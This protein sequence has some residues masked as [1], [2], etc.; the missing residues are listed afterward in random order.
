MIAAYT[1]VSLILLGRGVFCGWLC[2]FG[3]LQELLGQIGRALRLPQWSPTATT[4]RWLLS[5]KYVLA[6]GL[7]GLAVYSIEWATAL[8]E[9]EPFKTAITAG[10]ARAAPY[11]AYAALLL[12]VGLFVERFF[13]RY[14]CPLGGALA[15]LGRFHLIDNLKRRPQCGSPCHLCERSCAF[16][17]IDTKGKINMKRMLP[18]PGLPGRILRRYAMPAATLAAQAREH[19]HPHARPAVGRARD[20]SRGPLAF[21]ARSCGRRLEGPPA[22]RRLKPSSPAC[23]R[24][25]PRE[26]TSDARLTPPRT[27]S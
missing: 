13:C 17:V 4:D 1:A 26:Q 12:C 6:V 16:N 27:R 18:V 15:I 19:R 23:G 5:L 24:Q 8:S 20:A 7:I 22:R 11:A 14:L 21:S 10:F 2:P 25:L 3:A 9:I